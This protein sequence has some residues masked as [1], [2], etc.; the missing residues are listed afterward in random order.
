MRRS[1]PT[2]ARWPR[3]VCSP[4]SPPATVP[5]PRRP[6]R[7][8]GPRPRCRRTRR[9]REEAEES[10]ARSAS[11]SRT[12]V[13]PEV[14]DPSVDASHYDLDLTWDPDTRTL[15]GDEGLTFR[16]TGDTDHVQLDLTRSSKCR[17]RGRRCRT[18][19]SST[20][21]RTWSITGDFTEDGQYAVSVAYSGTPGAGRGADDPPDFTTTGFT[22]SD[23]GSAWTM[24]EPYGAYTWYAVNDQPSDKAFYDFILRAPAP[25]VGVANGQLVSHDEAGRHSRPRAGTST[26][27]RR[28]TSSPSRSATTRSPRTSRRAACRS[29]LGA[30]RRRGSTSTACATPRRRSTWVEDKLGPYPF[31][32]LGV[33][34]VDS[35]SGM[36]TQTMITLGNTDYTTSRA[37]LVHEIV[38]QWYG[39]QVTP[40]DWSDLWMNEGMAMY[41]QLVWQAE[42]HRR[43]ARA[44]PAASGAAPSA[45]PARSTARPP[46]TTRRRSARSR[47]TTDRR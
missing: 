21:V 29:L 45:G 19:S 35:T 10:T 25:M 11:P 41:L 22:I 14:G 30:R 23:D 43:A 12:R 20:R 26:A 13:Y 36:E 7:T 27:R 9:R 39:D 4:A 33:L 24:Q 37:V 47:S 31:S 1:R 44:D 46:R 5:T 2:G 42:E 40:S 18:P 32:S 15:T 3:R 17:R 28:R 8:R 16:S 34:L 38:H 6:R